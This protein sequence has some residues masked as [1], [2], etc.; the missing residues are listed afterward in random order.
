MHVL[1]DRRPGHGAAV[2]SGETVNIDLSPASPGDKQHA[3]LN[4]LRVISLMAPQ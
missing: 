4:V 1:F 3:L 2:A